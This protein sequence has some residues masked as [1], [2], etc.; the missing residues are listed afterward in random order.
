MPPPLVMPKAK[1]AMHDSQVRQIPPP[2][3][4][5]KRAVRD[6]I[7]KSDRASL[8]PSNESLPGGSLTPRASCR[9]ATD[10]GSP[11][12]GIWSPAT[13]STSTSRTPN[14]NRCGLETGSLDKRGG[15]DRDKASRKRFHKGVAQQH[16]DVVNGFSLGRPCTESCRFQKK[17]GLLITNQMLIRCHEYSFGLQ[18]DQLTQKQT[19]A[20]WRKLA[21]EAIST[22]AADG[23]SMIE[24]FTV[25]K[26]G[27]VCA[28]YW[29][30]A[31]GVTRSSSNKIL[32]AA[33]KGFIQADAE[34]QGAGFDVPRAD[35][36][37]NPR[38]EV[39]CGVIKHTSNLIHTSKLPNKTACILITDNIPAQDAIEWWYM[40]LEIENQMPNEACIT[41]RAV[42]WQCVYE[43][44]YVP[45]MAWWGTSKKPLSISRWTSLRTNGL[46]A[47][48]CDFYGS[49]VDGKPNV[50]MTL[51]E[52]PNHSNFGGCQRCDDA[53]RAWL[54]TRTTRKNFT[55]E[56]LQQMKKE[57]FQH[58][59]KMR[60]QRVAVSRLFNESV[61]TNDISGEMDDKCGS[62]YIHLPSPIGGREVGDGSTR[63][64]Y[65]IGLQGN[66]FPG[67]L[68]RMSI[69][70]PC[71]R[72]GAN[73]GC[74]AFLSAIYQMQLDKT[75]GEVAIR[76]TDSGP[77]NDA[78]VTHEFHASLIHYGALQKL[79]WIRLEPKHSHN[80]ADRMFSM[81]KEILWPRSGA[82]T[83]GCAAPWDLEDVIKK[84]L[85]TQKGSPQLAFHLV[86][87]DFVQYFKGCSSTETADFSDLRY[88]LQ[89]HHRYMHT[90]TN[91]TFISRDCRPIFN[92]YWVY[93]NDITQ[94]GGHGDVRV[95]YRESILL[96]DNELMPPLK[97]VDFV[98][99]RFE[100][101]SSGYRFML[102]YPKL[103]S[104]CAFEPW[105]P[106]EKEDVVEA[107]KEDN[108][109]KSHKPWGK[110]K[111]FSDILNH[112]MEGFTPSQRDQ[113][114]A[115]ES[116]HSTYLTS[117][118]V[119][120]LPLTLRWTACPNVHYVIQCGSFTAVLPSTYR[121]LPPP[122]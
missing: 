33:R 113:W 1:R 40:W 100:T 77:D 67:K 5:P 107:N 21:S 35:A 83:G 93:E 122:V 47:L 20:R 52:R 16:E 41:H 81:I 19:Q 36:S 87:F 89:P 59:L 42:I 7:F 74:T 61:L 121:S 117:D 15:H 109:K 46:R 69:V 24:H 110:K 14:P 95:H 39:C 111:V 72:T 22:S 75:L 114:R 30:A 11:R 90:R 49:D 3:A 48:S 56:Q 102:E 108:A 51:L 118:V 116:F 2:L 27:P 44:E 88:A 65:R 26:N 18:T 112:R 6:P 105:K 64:K 60:A 98:N 45:D 34:W 62:E 115:I 94:L 99:G 55:V 92:R 32:A 71:L 79:I 84:A 9:F 101:R 38:K 54:E 103:S 76:L 70:P 91:L 31:Y 25:D 23:T 63:W 96:P 80:L 37:Y 13:S 119:P 53:K 8:C 43:Q 66:L 120:A 106:A 82:L 12:V 17:C 104:G 68:L 86:N 78:R 58:A 57:I 73:F 97:P 4:M 50:M 85:Q 28:E 10:K 29:A